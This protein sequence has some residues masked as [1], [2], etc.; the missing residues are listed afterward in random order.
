MIIN[1]LD[2]G[3]SIAGGH[4]LEWD[5]SIATELV[6]QGHEL[7]VYSHA[8]IL[9]GVRAAF[10]GCAELVPVFRNYAY[11]HPQQLD[12][13]AGD[14]L[15]FIDVAIAL[16]EDLT[17][18][19][20]ADLWLWP[21]LF[22]AQLYACSLVRAGVPVSGCIHT[23]PGFMSSLGAAC[24]KYAFIKAGQAGL[25]VDLGVPGPILQQ[26]YGEIFGATG[27]PQLLPLPTRGCPV[28][29][30]RTELRTIGFF[31]HHR[32]EKGIQLIPNLVTSLLNEGYRIVLHDS[33]NTF[34]AEQIPGLTPIG[35]VPDLAA[36]IAKCDL[37]VLP[38]DASSYRSRESAIVWDALASGIPVVVPNGTA[39]GLRVLGSGAGKVALLP[40]AQSI[41]RA[42]AEAKADYA[43]IAAAAF[44][45]SQEWPRTHGIAKLANALTRS[46]AT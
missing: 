33:G 32:Q 11:L 35:Y 4:H 16:A 34:G 2:P 46:V 14:L 9:P 37:V 12:P 17:S 7:T 22:H 38:Y 19:K 39:P 43:Q 30:P 10:D 26:E 21:S 20:K 23:E 8:G 25:S 31:G 41:H 27:L 28:T 5:R 40:T 15:G 18:L 1:I 44:S 29:A 42:I 3:L 6:A 24:W 13:I 36:E 45:A